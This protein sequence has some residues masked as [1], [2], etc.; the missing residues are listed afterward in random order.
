MF[1]DHKM[2]GAAA[3]FLLFF[4][5]A[6]VIAYLSPDMRSQFYT[7]VYMA[8]GAMYTALC[9]FVKPDGQADK[10]DMVLPPQ[11]DSTIKEN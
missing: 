8:M 5:A 7:F 10:S 9:L 4:I 2:Q 1:N 3:L 6:G 11:P